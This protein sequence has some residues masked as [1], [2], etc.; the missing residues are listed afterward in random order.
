MHHNSADIHR[1]HNRRIH[2]IRRGQ[3]DL[4]PDVIIGHG[5][6]LHLARLPHVVKGEFARLAHLRGGQED[7]ENYWLIVNVD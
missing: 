6:E 3:F 1:L 2:D 5:F 4:D 7:N